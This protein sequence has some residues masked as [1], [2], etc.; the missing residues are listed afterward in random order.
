MSRKKVV[1]GP[2][3]QYKSQKT[4]DK[5]LVNSPAKKGEIHVPKGPNR[6]KTPEIRDF[7]PGMIA[8]WITGLQPVAFPIEVECQDRIG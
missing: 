5:F 3:A 8:R 2:K 7:L 4:F 1:S 6:P